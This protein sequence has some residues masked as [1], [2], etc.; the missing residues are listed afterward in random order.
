M[1]LP[2]TFYFLLGIGFGTGFAY[3]IIMFVHILWQHRKEKRA[4][5][6]W[7]RGLKDQY[8]EDME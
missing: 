5:A 1:T 6:A 3:S 2:E 4:F 7:E 8:K